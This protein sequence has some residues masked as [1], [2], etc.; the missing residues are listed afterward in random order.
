MN[1]KVKSAKSVDSLAAD[2]SSCLLVWALGKKALSKLDDCPLFRVLRLP[3]GDIT[4]DRAMP[5]SRIRVADF[6]NRVYSDER[7]CV[8]K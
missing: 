2:D 6:P 3:L 4:V 1:A 8:S 7:N 5:F